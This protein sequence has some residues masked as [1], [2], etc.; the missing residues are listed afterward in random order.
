MTNLDVE[1]MVYLA[2]NLAAHLSMS[3]EFM[4]NVPKSCTSF[5]FLVSGGRM[6]LKN[7]V[8]RVL[9]KP[10]THVACGFQYHKSFI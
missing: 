2:I 1:Q 10:A 7:L 8:G 4:L 9:K 5:L 6:T 3:M